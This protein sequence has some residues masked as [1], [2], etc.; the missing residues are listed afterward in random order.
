MSPGPRRLAVLAAIAF[1]GATMGVSSCSQAE[2]QINDAQKKLNSASR[3]LNALDA[4]CARLQTHP[5][6]LKAFLH[7]EVDNANRSD[8]SQAATRAQA[9]ASMERHCS[10]SQNPSYKPFTDVQI[11]ISTP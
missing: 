2:K 6:L 4:S 7:E 3:D 5:A 9:R 11:D 10:S 1:A 8:Q